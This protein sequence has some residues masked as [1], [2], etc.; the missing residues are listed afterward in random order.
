MLIP[1]QAIFRLNATTECENNST[2]CQ[3]D[4]VVNR[5]AYCGNASVQFLQET[6]TVKTCVYTAVRFIKIYGPKVL[7]SSL[8]LG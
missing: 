7:K 8:S 2:S 6:I 4:S 5:T 3:L 1:M